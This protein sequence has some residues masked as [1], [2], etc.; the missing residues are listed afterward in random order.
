[1]TSAVKADAVLTAP[2][3]KNRADML[4][5]LRVAATMMVFLL[6][7]RS[8]VAGINDGPRVLGIL[9]SMP[10]WAGVWIL[11]F[12]S[13]YLM[14]KGFLAGRYPV[15]E[16]NRLSP[17]AL[18]KFYWK[19]FLK[20]APAYY[21]YILLY[22]VIHNTT[23]L[24]AKP[25]VA[26]RIFFFAFNGNDG[27]SGIGHLWYISLAMWLYL[28]APFFY[29]LIKQINKKRFLFPAFFLLVGVGFAVRYTLYQT[30]LSWYD[31]T[32]TFL[33]CNFDL[34]V[35]GMLACSITEKLRDRVPQGLSLA[36]R[37]GSLALFLALVVYNCYIYFIDN[38]LIYQ[39]YLPT[40]YL[41]ITALTAVC[42]DT[43]TV[44]REK[45][46]WGAVR[47]NPLRLIDK[48]SPLT[49]SFY[50]LH[51]AV[52]NHIENLLTLFAGYE[53]LPVTARYFIFFSIS[54]AATLALSILFQK[55]I[56]GVTASA[57]KKKA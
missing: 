37:I 10:A 29:F 11:F 46:T 17:R 39:L 30:E 52:F 54:F 8:T 49:Y 15:F 3:K 55:M 21:I 2:E 18:G 40:A 42:H 32:Y 28:L 45:P 38:Y 57:K 48:F 33:P 13:G 5:F 26:L 41:L 20:I 25:L 9:S 16:G 7:G 14:Q 47:R 19:R 22:V 56:D 27:I 50:I 34:F 31:W 44:V 4:N 35:G 51:I 6:H 43:V 36:L 1:M 24:L 23:Y 53:G 12:L